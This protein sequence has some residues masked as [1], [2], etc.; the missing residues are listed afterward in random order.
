MTGET[1][2]TATLLTII[3][4]CLTLC[5]VYNNY[6]IELQKDGKLENQKFFESPKNIFEIFISPKK[7]ISIFIHDPNDHRNKIITMTPTS[8]KTTFCPV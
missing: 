1:G 6:A 4:L 3:N 5:L 2:K 8:I 7:A